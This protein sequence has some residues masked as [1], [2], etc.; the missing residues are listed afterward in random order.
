MSFGIKNSFLFRK[1]ICIV[2]LFMCFNSSLLQANQSSDLRYV[3]LDKPKQVFQGFGASQTRDGVL[4]IN[5]DYTP[6]LVEKMSMQVYQK[7]GMNW[8]RLWVV[9]SE[10]VGSEL[11]KYRFYKN[12]INNGLY[13]TL[14]Q[15]GVQKFLLA[16]ARG[17]KAPK[18][19]MH[20]YAKKLARFISDI[21]KERGVRIDVTGFA[22]EPQGFQHQQISQAIKYLRKELDRLGMQ[23]VGIIGPEW[24]NADRHA[25]NVL[26]DLE[27]KPEVWDALRGIST[28]SYTMAAIPLIEEF[29]LDSN[30]EYWMTEAGRGLPKIIDE[31]PGEINEASTVAAR[32][33]NDMNHSVTHWFWFIGFGHH[34]KHP[35][36]DSGHVLVKPDGSRT[37][38]IK[39]NSKYFYLKQLRQTFDLG[40][41]F[42]AVVPPKGLRSV[43]SY[44]QKPAL[45]LSAA[46]NLDGSWGIGLVNTTGINFSNPLMQFYEAKT[47]SVDI[48][49]PDEVGKK[50]F[51]VYRSLPDGI[52]ADKGVL[53]LKEGMLSIEISPYELVTLRSI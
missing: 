24:A 43:W 47:Y 5:R 12:Y 13:K 42:Y 32:F 49:L 8:T 15:S 4:I 37:G 18:E 39:F 27:S 28:H 10:N 38:G 36:K 19:P 3:V 31:N 2:V 26:A 33:L 45:T 25:A 21:Y 48:L 35:N 52:R 7:L 30:K 1:C 20:E 51:K 34:D 53:E 22:N 16:P 6:D 14:K 41:R 44:G 29:V 23:H 11:M 46:K 50:K 17:E 40:A 9:S